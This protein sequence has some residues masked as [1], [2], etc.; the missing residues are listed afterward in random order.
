MLLRLYHRVLL[1]NAAARSKHRLGKSICQPRFTKHDGTALNPIRYHF[2]NIGPANFDKAEFL[3]ETSPFVRTDDRRTEPILLSPLRTPLD[4]V[5]PYSPKAK[6][7]MRS[8]HLQTPIL[9]PSSGPVVTEERK[10][11]LH[12]FRLCFIRGPIA[13][14][15][16]R[17]RENLLFILGRLSVSELMSCFY[18]AK[19]FFHLTWIRPPLEG[20]VSRLRRPRRHPSLGRARQGDGGQPPRNAGETRFQNTE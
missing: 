19:G 11:L 16:R 7:G 12:E 1:G 17:R 2:P 6:A 5:S 15:I 8:Q 20:F 9:R 3:I 18:R 10:R 13:T 14:Y 4:Q